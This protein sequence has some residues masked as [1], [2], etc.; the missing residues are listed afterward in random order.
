VCHSGEE[1]QASDE[2]VRAQ[3]ERGAPRAHRPGEYEDE[4]ASKKE[5]DAA[6]QMVAEK[7]KLAEEEGENVA[8]AEQV[9]QVL[10]GRAQDS[11]SFADKIREL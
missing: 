6:L 1:L 2:A 7:R 8:S 5:K 4:R 10:R 9:G 3:A 11:R